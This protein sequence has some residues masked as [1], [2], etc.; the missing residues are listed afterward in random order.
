MHA[1]LLALL[2][3]SA[4]PAGPRQA[5]APLE[6]D[7][8]GVV[9]NVTV[10]S[11]KVPDVSSLEAWKASFLK[12][13][14]TDAEKALAVWR[15]VRTFQHQ[16]VPP[17]EYL[18]G[19]EIV[20]DPIKVFNVY[21]YAMCSPA[22]A[23]VTALARAAGLQ[24]RGRILNGHSVPEVFFDGAWR[25]LDASLLCYF[26]KADGTLAGV[27][28]IMAGVREWYEKNP[29]FKGDE[30]KLREFMRGGGWRRGPEIL[31]RCPQYDEN[32]WFEAATHG[33]YSTMMEYDGSATGFYEYGYSLGYRV[34]LQLRPGERLTRNWS[35][36]GLHVNMDRGG[37]P[38]CLTLR[39]GEGALRYT[40][41][42]GDLANGR[43]GN[44][45]LE[46]EMPVS[47][48]WRSGVLEATN[49]GDRP[50]VKDPSR[51]GVLVLRMPSSYVY[52]TGKL[53]YR[54]SGDVAVSYS[55]NHGLDWRALG[56][57]SGERT[58]DLS[59]HVLRRYDYRLRLE[60][61]GA[62]ARLEALRI[63]HDLQHSQRPLPALAQGPNTITFRAGP[64]EGT[65]TLEAP[66]GLEAKGKQLVYTDF[67]PDLRGFEPNLFV[68]P[69]GRGQ[70]T[71]PVS[72]P[73]DLVRLRFGTHYRAR[74]ARD[75]L[76][77]EV[78]FDDGKSWKTVDRA[79]GG[80]AGF[81]KYVTF[82]D[83]PA[84]TRRALV[85]FSATSRNA[86]GIFSFRIDA[87]YREPRGGFRPVK[88]TYVWEENGRPKELS[89]V[90][91]RPQETWTVTCA[92]RPVMKSIVLE[93][94]E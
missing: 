56:G 1:I 67:H 51:P 60:L 21:G 57:G 30:Q 5:P 41:K 88:V 77:Y 84:G 62:G 54:A 13:G 12:D 47:G 75:G 65:I 32:G 7:R 72:T 25:L 17:V 93:L 35:N 68:G 48:D 22:S 28:E 11:D 39:V 49:L 58:I 4:G 6:R 53:S 92:A 91:R 82:S 76:D 3:G 50:E 64:H 9:C 36:R 24:A 31:S 89:F 23:H 80:V 52:L 46:Y 79:P 44:G 73:G 20:Q 18:Q 45:T 90:A 27:D 40:P 94:A 33:W 59:P 78:S 29:G 26:P 8:A 10:L 81:C 38:G 2:G 15:T 86:T 66:G 70:I 55:D 43:V 14:M 19:D 87:D 42:D 69:S 85:R 34:N 16:D 61:R 63:A 83:I 71:F 37:A 74:D